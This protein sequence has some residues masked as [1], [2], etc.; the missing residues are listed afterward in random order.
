M[1]QAKFADPAPTGPYCS[2]LGGKTVV[3]QA[4][5]KCC[6]AGIY[7][8]G[9]MDMSVLCKMM[10][11]LTCTLTA[12]SATDLMHPVASHV[13]RSAGLSAREPRGMRQSRPA[14][15]SY[16]NSLGPCKGECTNSGLPLPVKMT[17]DV[18]HGICKCF[19]A[20][21]LLAVLGFIQSLWFRAA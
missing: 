13:F 10:Q 9:Q 2:C 11:L 7:N 14:C 8:I 19:E 4:L 3:A 16:M 12:S 5:F 21:W 20:S 6:T 1:P 17:A 15:S 18:S